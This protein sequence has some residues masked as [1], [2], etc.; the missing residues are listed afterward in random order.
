MARVSNIVLPPGF[1][2]LWI[3]FTMAAC[4]NVRP[5]PFTHIFFGLPHPLEPGTY[6]CMIK[7]IYEVVRECAHTSL[8]GSVVAYIKIKCTNQ[9]TSNNGE[10]H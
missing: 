3:K 2:F 4:P 6:I 9:I 10:I 8:K 7:S 5:E 1:S